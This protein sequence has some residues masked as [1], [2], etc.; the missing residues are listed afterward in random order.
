VGYFFM[1][2][3]CAIDGSDAASVI[4]VTFNSSPT[5]LRA[6]HSIPSACE[7]IVVDNGSS[8]TIAELLADQPV[9]LVRLPENIGF[10]GAS[11]IGAALAT[12]EFVLFLNPDA[13]LEPG[14]ISALVDAAQRIP[15]AAFNPQLLDKQGKTANRAPSR[16]LNKKRVRGHMETDP[17]I[18][19]VEVDVLSGAALFCRRHIFNE[20]GGFD[21]SLFLYFED[22]DLSL[23]LLKAGCRLFRHQRSV[24]RH[25]GGA[26][27][28]KS[29]ALE[30]FKNYHWERSHRLLCDKHGFQ[31]PYL[32]RLLTN[33]LH[34]FGAVCRG[35]KD[36]I[37]KHF[38]RLLAT[39][40]TDP[41]YVTH[42]LRKQ[43]VISQHQPLTL[44]LFERNRN[45]PPMTRPFLVE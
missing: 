31:Y 22:D 39:V 45:S 36:K 30:Q 8:D 13:V 17:S 18:D 29:S 7:V 27:T 40:G 37:D 35:K 23:R 9:K 38:G 14:A 24:V 3:D 20:I 41:K 21:P 10:G 19:D 5:I 4:L 42:Q 32:K 26:S 16:F 12:R 43:F 11:N 33:V 44:G 2:F 34:G 15:N 28:P 1:V 25:E 6:L